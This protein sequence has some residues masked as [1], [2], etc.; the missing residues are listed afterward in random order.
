MDKSGEY[1]LKNIQLQNKK[2]DNLRKSLNKPLN[3]ENCLN[4]RDINKIKRKEMKTKIKVYNILKI[5]MKNQM[6]KM[7]HTKLKKLI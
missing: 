5:L 2:K 7:T 3:L 1:Y 6:R 4:K